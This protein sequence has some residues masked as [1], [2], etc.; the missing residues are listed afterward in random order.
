[1][2]THS[3]GCWSYQQDSLLSTQLCNNT[4][5][6]NAHR[7]VDPRRVHFLGVGSKSAYGKVEPLSALCGERYNQRR[8]GEDEHA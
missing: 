2:C 3:G 4:V 1:M 5:L 6:F 8:D 7:L